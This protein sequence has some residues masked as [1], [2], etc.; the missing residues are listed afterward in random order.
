M[1]KALSILLAI[2]LLLSLAP[3]AV[4]AAKTFTLLV[5]MC[6]TDLESDGGLATADLQEMVASGVKRGGN[7]NVVVQTGGTKQWATRGMTNR[8]GERWL[9]ST[10]GMERLASLGRVNMGSGDTFAD[11]LQFGIA[12]YP[13]DRF[14]VIFWDHGAGS[15]DGV[16]YDEI[17]GESLDMQEIYAA[18]Q[19]ASKLPDYRKFAMVGFD[20]CLMADYEMAVHLAPFADLMVASEETEPGDGWDYQSWL[21][22]LAKDA[23][24]D[25]KTVGK[26]IV[27]SF[28]DHVERYSY[29]DMGTLSV[30]DLTQMDGLHAAMETMGAALQGEIDGGNFNS[31]SRIRQNVRSF[32]ETSDAASDMI[33]LGVFASIFAR[34][35]E[36]GASALRKALAE[37]VTYSRHTTNLNEI[38]GLAVLVPYSTRGDA[39][40]YLQVYDS[41]N[42]MPSYTSFVRSLANGMAS[43]SYTFASS[44]VTQQSV[45]DATVDWFSQFFTDTDSYY[46]AYHNT[47]AQSTASPSSTAEPDAPADDFSLDGFLSTLFGETDNSFNADAYVANSLWSSET[48]PTGSAVSSDSFANLWGD[49]TA[50]TPATVAVTAGD[51]TYEVQNPFAGVSGEDAYSI[52]LTE[53]D[54][55]NLASADALL[56]M[57]VSDPD[58]ECYVDLGYTQDVIID[59]NQGKVFGLFDGTWP[60]LDGQMVCIYDQVANENFVRSL[61]PVTVNGQDTYLLVI[62]DQTNPGGVVAGYTEGY[63]D[64]GQPVRGYE[65]LQA[66]DIVIPQYELIYWDAEDVQ[67]SEP[68]EGD[69]IVVGEDTAIPFGYDDVE[70]EADYV[71]GFC[72]NDVYGGYTYS[73]FITLSF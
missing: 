50:Q 27:D 51:E 41:Q 73:D 52:S 23:G 46:D 63:N 67:Q 19:Q 72:L 6:G 59:W 39:A 42:L 35:D 11:F 71:Y 28:I 34:Y 69:P 7:L 12:Q 61:I 57:D 5:Y 37:V 53:E 29:G 38:S 17:T 4:A 20:A 16:C 36:K 56:M 47:V 40:G 26:K 65:Q 31:I 22:M 14:G 66:G 49:S 1:K 33:D 44:P 8:E 60:T 24:A 45:Q 32:G 55:Q 58:F 30:L 54:M 18:F 48:A 15:S 13:A 70:G 9:L 64:A 25:M 43:G 62:F 21:P 3:T 68:F 10:Q 2:M